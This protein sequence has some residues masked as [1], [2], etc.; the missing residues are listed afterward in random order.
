[1]RFGERIRQTG[2]TGRSEELIQTGAKQLGSI[3]A[4]HASKPRICN[5]NISNP[6]SIDAEKA[7]RRL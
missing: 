2:W 7:K 4:G 3:D 6:A 5:K 1:M